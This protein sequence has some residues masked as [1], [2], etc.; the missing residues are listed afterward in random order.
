V[1][2]ADTPWAALASRAIRVALARGDVSYAALA[3]RLA[4]IGVVESERALIA[5]V[6]RGTVKLTLLL[7]IIQ[8]TDAT[9]PIFWRDALELAGTWEARAK[10][11]LASELLRQPWV[12]PS[13]LL[14]RLADIGVKT[15]DPALLTQLSAGTLPLSL[16]L[17]CVTVLGSSSV[18]NYLEWK[19]LVAAARDTLNA[20]AG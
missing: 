12:T 14:E 11:V 18:E 10:E 5:R 20:P 6:S 15:S 9:P 7:Q 16:F 4:S 13:R 8:V 17:Q 1:S 19:E 3:E 2:E